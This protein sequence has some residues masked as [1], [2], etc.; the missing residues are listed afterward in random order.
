MTVHLEGVEEVEV[1][2]DQ[3]E[4]TLFPLEVYRTTTPT[5]LSLEGITTLEEVVVT[6]EAEE[7]EEVPLFLEIRWDHTPP[8][9]TYQHLSK[10]N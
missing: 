1:V 4:A 6:Q 2:E 9:A 5:P 3:E 7:A 8:T 10:R